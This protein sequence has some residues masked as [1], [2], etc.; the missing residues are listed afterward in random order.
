MKA[1]LIFI[2]VVAGCIAAAEELTLKERVRGI[3]RLV[4]TLANHTFPTCDLVLF[5]E[6][7]DYETA[8]EKCR[9]FNL[10]ATSKEEGHLA[11]VN[12]E[13]KNDYLRM[14]LNV[15]LPKDEQDLYIYSA[16][17]WVWTGLRKTKNTNAKHIKKI[18]NR[19]PYKAEDWAWHDDSHP[20]DWH[21]WH[22]GQPDQRPLKKGERSDVGGEELGATCQE[23]TCRQNQ[24]RMSNDGRWD[25]GYAFEKHPYACDYRGRYICSAEKK[26]WGDA[27]KACEAAGLTLASVKSPEETEEL[28]Q[29][30]EYFLG[31]SKFAPCK[32]I[33][34]HKTIKGKVSPDLLVTKEQQESCA[35]LKGRWDPEHWAWIG[36]NDEW[37][38]G[39]E[40]H[41][42]WLDGTDVE[43]DGFPW[44]TKA[45]KDNGDAKGGG[46][47][48]LSIA[49]WG[50]FDDEFGKV[51]RPFVCECPRG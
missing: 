13:E 31:A 17:R 42:K 33:F 25:D 5:T 45:G 6:L 34:G 19:V 11:T 15:A 18:K 49:K 29:A 3:K 37:G 39:S 38:V 35:D 30:L 32:G 1:P 22:R 26:K 10:A 24:M 2:C 46:Q 27:K 8:G 48:S 9:T 4:K 50:E 41:F 36:G 43:Y 12:D 44:I 14:L 21:K 20:L 16:S 23:K 47:N 51:K 7:S 28:L 40:G